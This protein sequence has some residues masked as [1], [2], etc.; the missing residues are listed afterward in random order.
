MVGSP[1]IYTNNAGGGENEIQVP[2]DKSVTMN[3]HA[4]GGTVQEAWYCPNDN[5][6]DLPAITSIVCSPAGEYV[7]LTVKGQPGNRNARVRI[8]IYAAIQV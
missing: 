7:V 8:R 5:I 4:G 3:I 1:V 2:Q 6:A